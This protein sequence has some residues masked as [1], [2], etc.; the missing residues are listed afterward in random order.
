MAGRYGALIT[1]PSTL[2]SLQTYTLDVQEGL[3]RRDEGAILA[4]GYFED[5]SRHRGVGVSP[6][7]LT[8]EGEHCGGGPTTRLTLGSSRGSR[9]PSDAAGRRWTASTTLRLVAAASCAAAG[10][11]SLTGGELAEYNALGTVRS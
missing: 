10:G 1:W 4:F 5:V 9:R 8:C 11:R 2:D 6:D 7:L 3:I